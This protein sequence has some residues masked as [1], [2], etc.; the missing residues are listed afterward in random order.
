MVMCDL[1]ALNVV[2]ERFPLTAASRTAQPAS[3]AA[4]Q[5][6][7]CIP[8]TY[9]QRYNGNTVRL[10]HKSDATLD[11]RV[12]VARIALSLL[13]LG[14]S[15]LK[16]SSYTIA[17]QILFPVG[18]LPGFRTHRK[19][20]L[21]TGFSR[22]FK[23]F[24]RTCIPALLHTH[25][26]SSSS[27]LKNPV[28]PPLLTTSQ[29]S[30]YEPEEKVRNLNRGI[31]CN[32]L[33]IKWYNC[34]VI[35]E[36]KWPFRSCLS[37]VRV[38]HCGIH[39]DADLDGSKHRVL[40]TALL[41]LTIEFKA[42]PC[43][44]QSHGCG[45]GSRK[46]STYHTTYSMCNKTHA[47]MDNVRM[48]VRMICMWEPCRTMTLV[49]VFSRGSPVSP[50]PSIPRCS[51]RTSLHPFVGSQAL[52]VKSCAKLFTHSL[53]YMDPRKKSS[54][55]CMH[56][57]LAY[58]Q[59]E[60]G[61]IP[62]RVAGFSPSVNRA[63][64]C[65]WSAGFLGDLPPFHSGVAPYSPQSPSSALETTIG[66]QFSCKQTF[67]LLL[68]YR[69]Q[70]QRENVARRTA[71]DC[72]FFLIGYSSP[73]RIAACVVVSPVSLSRFLTLDAQLH[74]LLTLC[75]VSR[76]CRREGRKE[77]QGLTLCQPESRTI[78]LPRSGSE[79]LVLGQHSHHIQQ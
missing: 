22:R 66:F 39:K 25:L 71:T 52:D 16:S 5:R 11:M 78:I 40:D 9:L 79:R 3:G 21:V 29:R 38:I 68:L 50:A 55:P 57:L 54:C 30:S 17:S 45:Y 49:G 33:Y 13:N 18:S 47:D 34:R 51:I 41:K 28:L 15:R 73:H 24:F 72:C 23:V 8:T 37:S 59:G 10:A 1:E 76:K 63:G 42:L 20:P 58:H 6:I 26:A 35:A 69:R 75:P 60:P 70:S 12:G 74:S 2:Y 64:R 44:L 7:E 53:I 14:R 4:L 19:M 27:T 65:R 32:V 56:I 46:P 62:G 77:E 61:S 36:N 67:V 48:H 43:V 31:A